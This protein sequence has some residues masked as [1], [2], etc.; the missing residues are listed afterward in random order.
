MIVIKIGKDVGPEAIR[1][2]TVEI[3]VRETEGNWLFF[4]CVK[5]RQRNVPLLLIYHS[6]LTNKLTVPLRQHQVPFHEDE[7]PQIHR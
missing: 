5:E 2:K 7:L 3:L 6:H 4:I 1:T